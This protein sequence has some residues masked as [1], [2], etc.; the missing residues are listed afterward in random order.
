MADN[1]IQDVGQKDYSKKQTNWNRPVKQAWNNLV[2]PFQSGGLW[3]GLME[4]I[5]NQSLYPKIQEQIN[6]DLGEE[7][8][9]QPNYEFGSPLHDIELDK[10]YYG[11]DKEYHPLTGVPL[12]GRDDRKTIKQ[13]IKNTDGSNKEIDVP[14]PGFNIDVDDDKWSK[15]VNPY[16]DDYAQKSVEWDTYKQEKKAKDDELRERRRE[17][18]DEMAQYFMNMHENFQ[19]YEYKLIGEE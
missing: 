18:M 4:H 8:F 19:P 3:G 12:I 15:M 11:E 5:N 17:R 13:I 1:P 9:T 14:N 7:I 6:E 2:G 10:N 16:T